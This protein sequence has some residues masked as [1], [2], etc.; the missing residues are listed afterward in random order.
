M[1]L[2]VIAE[3]ALVAIGD[4]LLRSSRRRHGFRASLVIVLV[5]DLPRSFRS[6]ARA[7]ARMGRERSSVVEKRHDGVPDGEH[8]EKKRER[9]MNEEPAVEPVMKPD[10]QI[11]HSAFVAPRL[12]FLEPA[13][14]TFGDAQ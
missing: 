12:D 3:V 11:E 14:V 10:L 9:H 7:R 13:A 1:S 5:L 2:F 6:R 8:D 4:L